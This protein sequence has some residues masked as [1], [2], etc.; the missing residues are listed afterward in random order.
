MNHDQGGNMQTLSAEK[1]KMLAEKNGWTLAYAEGYVE[2]ETLRRGGKALSTYAL[3]GI[4]E[5]ALGF[6][7]G[8]F[9]RQTPA[10]GRTGKA[11]L[12][13]LGQKVLR[14]GNVALPAAPSEILQSAARYR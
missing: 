10:F 11:G 6:R 8:F 1:S 14:P 13:E 5:Y 4:D 9:E 12:P 7:A 2:G 3:V